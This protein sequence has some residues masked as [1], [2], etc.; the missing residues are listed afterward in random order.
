MDNRRLR[1]VVNGLQLGNVYD[2][3]GHGGGGDERAGLLALEVLT[4]REGGVVHAVDVGAGDG[5]VVSVLAGG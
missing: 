2:V 1:H 3:A 5:V 4:S